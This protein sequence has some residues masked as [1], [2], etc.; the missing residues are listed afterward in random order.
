[1]VAVIK[2]QHIRSFGDVSAQAQHKAVGVRGGEGGLPIFQL[3]AALQF[4]THPNGVFSGQ[5]EGDTLVKLL[6]DFSHRFVGRMTN[7]SAGVTQAEVQEFLPSAQVK[8]APLASV[9]K[10]GKPPAQ[11]TIQFM[12]TPSNRQPLARS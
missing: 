3:E 12:G 5:H 9:T 11:R 2:Y 8:E 1:M 4:F 7:H 10:S 6:V